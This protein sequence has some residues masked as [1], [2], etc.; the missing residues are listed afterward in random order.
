MITEIKC[1]VTVLVENTWVNPIVMR[2]GDMNKAKKDVLTEIFIEWGGL[3]CPCCGRL[4][5]TRP[6]STR[7]KRR[8]L[9]SERK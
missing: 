7:L 1:N 6:R 9:L 2:A 5:R 8:V 3:W 4:L